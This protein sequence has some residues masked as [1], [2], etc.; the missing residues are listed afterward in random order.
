MSLNARFLRLRPRRAGSV[1]VTEVDASESK[2]ILSIRFR[3]DVAPVAPISLGRMHYIRA[4]FEPILQAWAL[5]LR[6]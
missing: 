1:A 5:I 6:W 4:Y 3:P 2:Q